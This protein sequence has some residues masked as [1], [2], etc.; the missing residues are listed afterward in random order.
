V[1]MVDRVRVLTDLGEIRDLKAR[2]CRLVDSGYSTAGDDANA[3]AD[4]FASDGVW[5]AAGERIV[6]R[7][8]I[9]ERAARSRRF[10]FHLASNPIVDVDGDSATGRWHALVAITG[11]DGLAAW[12]AGTYDDTFVRTSDGWRFEH[13]RFSVAFNAPYDEGWGGQ[14]STRGVRAQPSS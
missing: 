13:V 9:R 5:E 12:L 14:R 4:L 1:S 3:F 7:N 11:S 6:G 2:Y 8:A 10:R